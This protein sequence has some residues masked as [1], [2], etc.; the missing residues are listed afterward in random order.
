MKIEAVGVDNRVSFV[1]Y[2]QQYGPQHD[3]SY[4]PEADFQPSLQ[5]PAYLLLEEGRVVGAVAL[6]CTPRFTQLEKARFAIFHS[7]IASR[8]A[9]AALL[10]AVRPHLVGLQSAYLFIPEA[11]RETAAIWRELGF[12]IERYAYVLVLREPAP[13]PVNLSPDMAVAALQPSDKTLIEQYAEAINTN[14]GAT[15]G[16]SHMQPEEVQKMFSEAGYLAGGICLLHRAGLAIGTL[17]VGREYSDPQA[18]EIATLS[19][20]PDWRGQGLGRGLLRHGI[21][22]A[23]EAGL[24]PVWLSVNAE[25]DSAL[26]L[27][28]FEGFELNETVACYAISYA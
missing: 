28:R 2:A 8:E 25:N 20:A 10:D 16:H 21:N 12:K 6:L 22:L 7:V 15:A 19:I 26:R 4:L 11:R 3:E 1:T 9:Y 27:Y 13:R 5:E 18:G 14:F 17:V 24:S 23:C